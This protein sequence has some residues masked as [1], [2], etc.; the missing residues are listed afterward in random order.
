MP[1][2]SLRRVR[3]RLLAPLIVASLTVG[4]GACGSDDDESEDVATFEQEGY[5]ITFDYPSDWELT[6]DVEVATQLGGTADESVAVG[7]DESNGITVERYT[8]NQEVTEADLDAVQAEF[9]GLITQADPDA[10]STTGEI[11]GLPSVSYQPIQLT[12]PQDLESR[13]TAVFDGDQEY[14][15]NCQ[16]TPEQIETIAAACDQAL[17]TLASTS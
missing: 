8:L 6:T 1:S 10:T 9:D 14:L 15:L 16:A 12:E 17:E 4:L 3:S 7:L 11:A 2:A 13:I 5:A